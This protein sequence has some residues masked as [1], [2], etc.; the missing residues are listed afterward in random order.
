MLCL[1]FSPVFD[2]N[3]INR[4]QYVTALTRVQELSGSVRNENA[5]W[6]RGWGCYLV[7]VEH[8]MQSL[9]NQVKC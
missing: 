9:V 1:I 2:V 6:G 8:I 3:I 7:I 4:H 5:Q